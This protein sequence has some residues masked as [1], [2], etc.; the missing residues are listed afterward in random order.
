M[1]DVNATRF[2]VAEP[3]QNDMWVKGEGKRR[4]PA[5]VSEHEGRLFA[6]MTG[7]AG[8]TGGG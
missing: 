8:L 4:I 3:P 5:P 7:V 2:F 1:G 6:G